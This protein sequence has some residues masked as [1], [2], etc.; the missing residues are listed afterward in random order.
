M[1][2]KDLVYLIYFNVQSY[3]KWALYLQ[4]CNDK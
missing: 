2:Q 3:T 4:L 1:V